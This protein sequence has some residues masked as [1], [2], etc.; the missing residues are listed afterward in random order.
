MHFFVESQKK[1]FGR[2]PSDIYVWIPE[3]NPELNSTNLHEKSPDFLG[4]PLRDFSEKVT[5]QT[6]GEI[7]VENSVGNP[8]FSKIIAKASPGEIS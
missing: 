5:K 3:G 2:I 1:L 8:N 4:Y 7:L 6:P